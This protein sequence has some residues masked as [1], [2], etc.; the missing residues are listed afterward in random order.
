MSKILELSKESFIKQSYS[1]FVP[2]EL[3]I[4]IMVS[5]VKCPFE[6]ESQND[7]T[8]SK[9]SSVFIIRLTTRFTPKYTRCNGVTVV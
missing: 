4:H 8:Y 6:E 5:E 2:I 1:L 7:K 9:D 3:G